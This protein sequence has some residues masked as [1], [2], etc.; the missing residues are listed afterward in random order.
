MDSLDLKATV[1]LD[2]D[3]LAA[4]LE[5]VNAPAPPAAAEPPPAAT[6]EPPPAWMAAPPAGRRRSG[7]PPRRW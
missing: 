3:A 2:G 5:A 7:R 1:A 4:L 6:N